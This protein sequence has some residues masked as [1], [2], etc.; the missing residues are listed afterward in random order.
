MKSMRQGA[1]MKASDIIEKLR[2]KHAKDV[3]LMECKTGPSYSGPCP[4]L[5]AWAMN[6]SWAHHCCTGYEVKVSRSDF[7]NDEKTNEYLPFCHELY[8]VC[9]WSLIDPS[10]V[11]EYAGLMWASPNSSMVV[12]KK[13]A[14]KRLEVDSMIYVYVLIGF[15][16]SESQD[17]YRVL[18]LKSLG[19]DPFVMPFDKS[20]LYQKS[21]ARWV[22]HKAI[23]NKVKWENYKG[24]VYAQEAIGNGWRK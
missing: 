2:V 11:P 22:N 18:I 15:N 7:M 8:F 9:P 17:L 24:R 21:F 23:F 12:R 16:T 19:I 3:F 4:R 14:P 5:D 20:D 10:E 13:K 6:K 1:D